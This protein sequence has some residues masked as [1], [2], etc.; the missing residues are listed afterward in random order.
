MKHILTLFALFS[1]GLFTSCEGDPGPPGPPGEPGI[2]ILGQVF[3]ANVTFNNGNGFQQLI[4]IPSDIEVF[5]SDV[6]LVYWLE[7]VVGDG[8]GGT[9]DV[10]SQLPQTIYLDGGGSFQYTFNHTFLDVLLFLQGDIDLDT[11]GSGFTDDQ[12]FR[13]AVVPSEFGSADLTM[14][15]LMSNPDVEFV[16]LENLDN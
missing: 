3:E 2:N 15:E 6:I 9:L 5:E 8:S 1:I 13:I 12:I 7:E 4:T 14:E 16:D 11:L 10:W